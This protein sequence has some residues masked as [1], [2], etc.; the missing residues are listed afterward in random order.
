M[1]PWFDQKLVFSKRLLGVNSWF[2]QKLVFSKR[3]LP[4]HCWN[5]I[6]DFSCENWS[7]LKITTLSG[8]KRM[9]GTSLKSWDIIFYDKN[10]FVNTCW[11]HDAIFLLWTFL[12]ILKNQHFTIFNFFESR[13]KSTNVDQNYFCWKVWHL[14]FLNSCRR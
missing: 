7:W 5:D 10:N 11:P 6:N 1:N 13:Q 8:I 4:T 3:F 9:V 2:D 12:E 14:S